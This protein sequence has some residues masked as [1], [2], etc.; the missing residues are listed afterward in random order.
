M[1]LIHHVISQDHMTQE[2]SNFLGTLDVSHHL[3][4]FSEH[5]HYWTGDV[6]FLVCHVIKCSCVFMGASP[7]KSFTILPRLVTINTEL[8][9]T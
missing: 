5:R 3:A 6:I 8:M 7:S 9:K 4:K 1:F 2:Q